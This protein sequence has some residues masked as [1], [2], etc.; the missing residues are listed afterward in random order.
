MPGGSL[1]WVHVEARSDGPPPAAAF[2]PARAERDALEYRVPLSVAA[3][4]AVV[5]NELVASNRLGFRD[6][7]GQNAACIEL[8]T[9]P[10]SRSA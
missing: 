5:I 3:G 6:P 7:Q 10:L 4:S 2:A 8:L 9:Q 1:V